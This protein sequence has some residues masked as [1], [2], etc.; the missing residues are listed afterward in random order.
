MFFAT[1][2]SIFAISK[3]WT[4]IRSFPFLLCEIYE[5]HVINCL[6]CW[7]DNCYNVSWIYYLLKEIRWK[8]HLGLYILELLSIWLLRF[9]S[10]QFDFSQFSSYHQL[11]NRN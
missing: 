8:Y 3:K 1:L 5:R 9:G 7:N 4:D 11:T 2:E 10:S 6:T